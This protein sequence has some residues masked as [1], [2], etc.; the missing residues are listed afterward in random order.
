MSNS[1]FKKR[2]EKVAEKG[3]KPQPRET[4]QDPS[5][6]GKENLNS[7]QTASKPDSTNT[8]FAYLEAA[9]RLSDVSQL[10]TNCKLPL[11]QDP[12]EIIGLEANC[13]GS[14]N[15]E[16]KCDPQPDCLNNKETPGKI[17]GPWSIEEDKK[18]IDWVNKTKTHNWANCAK[19][20]TGRTGKQCRERWFNALS[21]NV[22]KGGWTTK[23]DYIIFR[24]YKQ[25]G[26]KWSKI[27]NLLVGR[28]EN[29]IKNRF[30]STLRRI[31]S[32]DRK[33]KLFFDASDENFDK[34][35]LHSKTH[36]SELV[37]FVDTALRE[38]TEAYLDELYIY[39]GS[40]EDFKAEQLRII[41]DFNYL[42]E[43]TGLNAEAQTV[44]N[45][46]K[47][48]E[49]DCLLGQKRAHADDFSDLMLSQHVESSFKGKA[50][51]AL[52]EGKNYI[53][54]SE[55]ERLLNLE[56]LFP[57]SQTAIKQAQ[58]EHFVGSKTNDYYNL[59]EATSCKE[60]LSLDFLTKTI[61]SICKPNYCNANTDSG[62]DLITSNL[63]I[64]EHSKQDCNNLNSVE[65]EQSNLINILNNRLYGNKLNTILLQLNELE[66]LLQ[67][68]KNE[69]NTNIG[70]KIE[71][72]T[73]C[74]SLAQEAFQ[75]NSRTMNLPGRMTGRR[76]A[77]E[78]GLAILE[79]V[80]RRDRRVLL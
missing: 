34:E 79:R 66:N 4:G 13:N 54:N 41:E 44:R 60:P 16:E 48:M 9:Y 23:E 68:T 2:L 42:N 30:Y 45:A 37:N 1:V 47:T 27:A 59:P 46:S 31:A 49:S 6:L 74:N 61:E 39:A 8:A 78:T 29:S 10:I 76:K 19:V 71:E 64:E 5:S 55:S 57:S 24:F 38:K 22:K 77:L 21:P 25:Y 18:L 36:I 62:I 15:K 69:L 73:D 56:N 28:T 75:F 7:T 12:S 80:L 11:K 63:L 52:S 40:N 20:I 14:E 17:K 35:L 51:K 33:N 67:N 50:S 53:L 26:S 72:A 32:Q 3:D 65:G 43:Q 70:N 58:N